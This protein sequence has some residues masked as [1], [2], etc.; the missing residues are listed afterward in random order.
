MP[1]R[2]FLDWAFSNDPKAPVPKAEYDKETGKETRPNILKYNSPITPQYILSMFVM[3]GPLNH[4]LDK[5][6]NSIGLY[7]IEK[8]ELFYF[9]RKCIRD[10]KISRNSIPYIKYRRDS[11][12]FTILR[13]KC[14]TLKGDDVAL[15]CDIIDK[16]DDKD[17]LYHSLNLEKPEK[18]KQKK[19]SDRE[20]I[21]ESNVK[22]FIEINF[23]V[24]KC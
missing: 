18:T 14:P 23:S 15:L 1:F 22:K 4:Y 21:K 16:S 3:N 12:L 19:L 6:F 24:L 13:K 5:Y 11:K 17:L 2:T 20:D 7:Y 8:E 10:Y 9:I